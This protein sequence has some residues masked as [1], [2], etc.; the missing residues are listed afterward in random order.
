MAEAEPL[1]F[2]P[3]TRAATFPGAQPDEHTW[4]PGPRVA[5]RL[6][7]HLPS[8]WQ[9]AMWEAPALHGQSP[10]RRCPCPGPGYLKGGKL[11]VMKE[12]VFD[13]HFCC[14][15]CRPW[16]LSGWHSPWLDLRPV[17]SM[18]RTRQV[19]CLPSI[20]PIFLHAFFKSQLALVPSHIFVHNYLFLHCS[21]CYCVSVITIML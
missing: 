4:S 7:A 11:R 19:P 5:L 15:K 9:T 16:H 10:S 21:V 8:S 2:A 6:P 3:G 13:T 1:E 20:G 14:R 18:R 17:A 12:A